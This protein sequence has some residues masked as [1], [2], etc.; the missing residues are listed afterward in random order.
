[1]G[2]TIW[3][4]VKSKSGLPP[5]NLNGSEWITRLR[6]SLGKLIVELGI[7]N[8]P[9]LGRKI[10]KTGLQDKQ[11][12]LPLF[13][14]QANFPAIRQETIHQVKGE[15]IEAVLV[16]G[17][18]MFWNSV[19]GSVINDTN[20]EDRRLAYVAM[21]RARHLLVVGLPASHYDKHAAKWISWGFNELRE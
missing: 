15:S 13:E 8:A 7:K 16:L 6:D 3:R 11:M 21:T 17:S 10:R 12:T 18:S 14:A 9:A 2:L 20:S 19:V 1:M 5:L 4:Y